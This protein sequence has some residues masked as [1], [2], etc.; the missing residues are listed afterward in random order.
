M[1]LSFSRMGLLCTRHLIFICIVVTY[2][3]LHKPKKNAKYMI[4]RFTVICVLFFMW[5][6]V[7]ARFESR[8]KIAIRSKN[9]FST[10]IRVRFGIFVHTTSASTVANSNNNDVN[11]SIRLASQLFVRAS[12][13]LT[14]ILNIRQRSVLSIHSKTTKKKHNNRREFAKKCCCC[15]SLPNSFLFCLFFDLT[16]KIT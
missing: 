8:Q 12:H 2:A 10:E 4:M 11:V 6:V 16:R 15:C 14:C 5:F 1:L 7:R 9:W 3:R 13:K